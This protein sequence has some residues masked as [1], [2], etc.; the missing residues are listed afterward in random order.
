[1]CRMWVELCQLEGFVRRRASLSGFATK[2][3]QNVTLM[4][5]NVHQ[6]IRHTPANAILLRLERVR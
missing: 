2:C 6:L 5:M 4:Y 1:M 3:D